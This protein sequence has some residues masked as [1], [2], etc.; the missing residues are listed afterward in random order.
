MK[1]IKLLIAGFILLF[2]SSV[3]TDTL[4][5]YQITPNILL[6][7]VV[8]ISIRLDYK[9]CLTFTFF[10]SIAN[11]L[12]NPQLLGFS[13]ILFVLLSHFTHQHNNSFNKDKFLT[14]LF[15]LF[16]INIAFYMIQWLYFSFSSYEPLF[17]LRKTLLTIVYNTL[18]SCIVIT[19]LFFVDRLRITLHE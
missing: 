1:Y 11:D 2:I 3:S 7:W 17:L 15:S 6:P 16:V 8:Y 13:T 10:L 12:L 9:Y 18:I 5:M 4:T 19:G 14:I